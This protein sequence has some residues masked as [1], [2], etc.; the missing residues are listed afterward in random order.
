[1]NFPYHFRRT[2][3]KICGFTR[4]QDAI[5]AA[6]LGVDAV[7][8]VFYPQSPRA[9]DIIQAQ[10]IVRS[11]PPF[12]TVVALFV[13]ERKHRIREVLGKVKIDLIQFHGEEDPASCECFD[14]P[15]IKAIAMRDNSD[16][17]KTAKRYSTASAL[18]L[19]AW[20][21][22][23]KGGTGMRFDWR[24]VSA[25]SNLPIIL[26][27]GL[28]AENAA[29]AIETVRPFGLDVSSGVESRK[30]IKDS[31]KMARFLE[32]VYNVERTKNE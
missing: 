14:M 8:L 3:V 2:R 31:K 26:A 12:V 5:E 20:H 19:D 22:D 11:L 1:M 13:N 30:G 25:Q 29:E 15:Y 27:G 28:S 10:E 17:E 23:M 21:P 32:E 7:G 18:L 9:V 24:R 16:L 4:K 6:L